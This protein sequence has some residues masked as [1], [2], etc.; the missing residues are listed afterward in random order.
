MERN[1]LE[2]VDHLHEH[3]VYPVSINSQGRYNIPQKSDEGYSIRVSWS[4]TCDTA[5]DYRRADAFLFL[6][7][8]HE[9]A[10]KVF[11]FPNGSYWSTPEAKEAHKSAF[12]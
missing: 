2:Y 7:Q 1:V 5:A 8:M 10:I 4:R 3:F 9:D 6:W 12:A 11:E